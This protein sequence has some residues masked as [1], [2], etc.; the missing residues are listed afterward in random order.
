MKKVIAISGSNATTSINTQLAKYL[1]SSLSNSEGEYVDLTQYELPLL[2]TDI[3]K[4]HGI[5][6]PAQDLLEVLLTADAFIIA[7]PEHNSAFPAFLKNTID[8]VSRIEM[9]FFKK[10][11]TLVVGTSPGPGGAR[12]AIAS[13]KPVIG[14]YMAA[15]IIDTQFLPKFYDNF[16]EG[17]IINDEYKALFSSKLELLESR[18]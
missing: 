14:G 3:Q 18:L 7:T 5:P 15:D 1:A 6:Q 4:E 9:D 10:K 11:P 17:E 12:N 13:L 8:W 16:K 2:N